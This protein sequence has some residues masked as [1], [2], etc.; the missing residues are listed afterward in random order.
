MSTETTVSDRQ[1]PA[2]GLPR[3]RTT[4]PV[5]P[6]FFG[7]YLL[8]ERL[9]EGGMGTVYRATPLRRGPDVALKVLSAHHELEG[10]ATRFA[11]EVA[12]MAALEHPNIVRVLDHG[13]V[14]GRPYYAMELLR[15]VNLRE[16]VERTGPQPLDRVLAILEPLADAVAATHAAGLIHRDVKPGNVM[17]DPHAPRLEPRL[18]D[19]G[20]VLA[21]GGEG[22][23]ITLDGSLLGTPGYLAPE[24]MLSARALSAASDLYGL[25]LTGVHLLLG[26]PVFRP[27]DLTTTELHRAARSRAFDTLDAVRTLPP[28]LWTTLWRS[29]EYYPARR[30]SLDQLR[31]VLCAERTGTPCGSA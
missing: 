20:L 21:P 16:L 4:G 5:L 8:R 11:R 24:G 15:G 10:S 6:A 30:P 7:R 31:A 22:E 3:R 2:R 19:F 25:A 29:L 17:L 1:T 9:G 28:A 14:G 18:L 23:R 26:A 13:D 12:A 27:H